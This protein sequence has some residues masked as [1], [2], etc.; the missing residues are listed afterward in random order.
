LVVLRGAGGEI[1][2]RVAERIRQSIAGAQIPG[3]S[4][5]VTVSAGVASRAPGESVSELV[6][7]ADLALYSAKRDG[8]DRVLTAPPS[9]GPAPMS[10]AP[11]DDG[12]TGIRTVRAHAGAFC[13]A[14]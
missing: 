5:A 7:R 8:R 4:R 2:R 12:V 13:A 10:E 6:A 3:L 14:E 9:A 1:A 11:F